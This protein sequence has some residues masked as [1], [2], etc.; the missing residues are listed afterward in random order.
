M[1]NLF[2][3]FSPL[4]RCAGT[5]LTNRS[6]FLKNTTT[7]WRETW[8]AKGADNNNRATQTKSLTKLAFKKLS[9]CCQIEMLA[10]E[11]VDSPGLT[12]IKFNP[13]GKKRKRKKAVTSTL[14]STLSALQE[15]SLSFYPAWFAS[16]SLS[17]TD[18]LLA[19][20]RERVT[21]RA[22]A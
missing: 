15:L 4:S 22:P 3:F 7:D 13:G 6:V 1:G 19:H 16:P 10:T 12:Q 17:A 21:H 14:D 5:R 8:H 2:F 18:V 11:P 9:L 20:S